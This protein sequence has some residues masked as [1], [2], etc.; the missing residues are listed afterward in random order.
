MT[1][2]LRKNNLRWILLYVG[3]MHIY[4]GLQKFFLKVENIPPY[5]VVDTPFQIPGE[6]VELA[7]D[8]ENFLWG[9]CS[10]PGVVIIVTIILPQ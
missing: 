5:K 3:H 9:K 10:T 6:S 1:L 8:R 7:T 2:C 4:S